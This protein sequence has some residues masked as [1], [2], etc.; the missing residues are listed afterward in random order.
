MTGGRGVGRPAEL[1]ADDDRLA[2]LRRLV[3]LLDGAVAIPGTP[4]RF[5]LDALIGLVPG[6]GDL[7]G[8]AL[9]GFV[10][11]SAARAGVPAAV[12][13]R[14]VLNVGIDALVGAVP[15]LGDLFDVAW[16]A[17]A[18]NLAL[19]EQAV[20]DPGRARRSSRGVLVG[21]LLLLAAVLVAGGWLA[22][23]VTRAVFEL[24]RG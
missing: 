20:G 16:R 9:S 8:A 12:L 15:I 1:R 6:V 18:R 21:V 5:G 4:V 23:V 3:R 22:F 19:L 17:N 13:L 7:A 24:A 10:V 2:A 14:M 11:L